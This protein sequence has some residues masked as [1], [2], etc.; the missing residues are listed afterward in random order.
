[1]TESHLIVGTYTRPAPHLEAARGHGLYVMR[2]DDQSG[3]ANVLSTTRSIENPSYFCVSPDGTMV[4]TIWELIE[5]ESGLVTSYVLDASGR[6][7]EGG[8]QSSEGGL[9]CYIA[10]DSQA[11]AA[12]VANYSTG[13]V[14]ML[15]SA[16]TGILKEATTIHKHVG[17][18]PNQERQEGPHPHCIVVDP[19]DAWALCAD[20]GTD[21]IYTYALDFDSASME[22]VSELRLPAGSGPRHLVFHPALPLA[23]VILELTSEIHSLR[24]NRQTGEV[25]SIDRVSTLPIG[26]EGESFAADIQVHPTGRHVYGSNRGHDSVAV[27]DVDLDNG[28]LEPTQICSTHGRTPRNFAI[29]P[30]GEWLLA[31]NQDSD[32]IVSFRINSDGRLAPASSTA[33]IPTPA[34]V[35]FVGAVS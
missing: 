2:F 31:A 35:K 19:T 24:I 16:A 15:P 26:Y 30:N 14:A 5:W 25:A 10:M 8:V 11:R 29:S 34:C 17:S 3:E 6:L 13:T 1:M 7:A 18:G 27:F 22:L 33:G 12:V 23:F 32:S 21:T 20:L 4:H 28:R 9:A